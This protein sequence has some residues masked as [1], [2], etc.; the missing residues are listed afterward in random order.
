MVNELLVSAPREA[1]WNVLSKMDEAAL[2]ITV[3]YWKYRQD[4]EEWVFMLASPLVSTIGPLYIVQQIHKILDEMPETAKGDLVLTDFNVVN[5]HMREIDELRS[6][7]GSINLDR[8]TQIK[9]KNITHDE[10][11]IYRLN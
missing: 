1:A 11:D 9:R 6:R 3:A 10:L 5:P 7:K 8:S 4:A 2:Q